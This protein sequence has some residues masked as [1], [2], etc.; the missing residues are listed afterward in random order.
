MSSVVHPLGLEPRTYC[1]TTASNQAESASR[2]QVSAGKGPAQDPETGRKSAKRGDEGATKRRPLPAAEREA[3]ILQCVD[4]GIHT[5]REIA[6][7][8][9]YDHKMLARAVE[10]SDA[11]Q[12][13]CYRDAHAR[14]RTVLV[15]TRTGA[16]N[17][18]PA[19]FLPAMDAGPPLSE[20]LLTLMQDGVARGWVEIAAALPAYQEGAVRTAISRAVR[21]EKLRMV[22]RLNAAPVYVAVSRVIEDEAPRASWVHPI[23]ARALG[24]PVAVRAEGGAA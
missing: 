4:R 20:Q 16:T 24:L 12:G 3:Q 22:Q 7:V 13:R 6:R 15:V 14:N 21:T 19:R 18:A 17:P 9:G 2:Q 10:L 5:L 1:H 11:V 23:R 8:I